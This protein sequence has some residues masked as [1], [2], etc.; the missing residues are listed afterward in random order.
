ME[1]DGALETEAERLMDR[2]VQEPKLLELLCPSEWADVD[3]PQAAE[4][5][6]PQTLAYALTDSPTG[7]AA[8]IAEKFY[9]WTDHDGDLDERSVDIDSLLTNI[10]R[11]PAPGWSAA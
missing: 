11:R 10:T 6:R 1:L 4:G 9:V 7:L 3:R 5:T 8:W 2:D